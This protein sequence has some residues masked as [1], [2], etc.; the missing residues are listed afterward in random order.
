MNTNK[1]VL[2]L[3]MIFTSAMLLSFVIPQEGEKE[4]WEIPEKYKKMKNPY[5]EDLSLLK[6]GKVLYSKHCRSCH[7]NKGLGDGAKSTRLKTNPGVFTSDIF[8]ANTD[9]EL[10]YKSIIGRDEM[11]NYEKKIPDVEDRWALINY[12]KAFK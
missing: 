5:A 2:V 1:I 3:V 12:I 6:V 4:P 11:P 10:Y 7:G 8:K 9:G